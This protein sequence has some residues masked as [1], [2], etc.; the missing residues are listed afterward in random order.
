MNYREFVVVFIIF[1]LY[2]AVNVALK[3]ASYTLGEKYS[4]TH[5]NTTLIAFGIITG[6]YF[7]FRGYFF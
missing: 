3:N 2:V 4:Q 7:V 6:L 1:I 5:Q